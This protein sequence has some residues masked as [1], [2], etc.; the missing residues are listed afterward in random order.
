MQ[1]SEFAS[2]DS[3]Q[4]NFAWLIESHPWFP[5]KFLTPKHQSCNNWYNW[6]SLICFYDTFCLIFFCGC[7]TFVHM[8]NIRRELPK[9]KNTAY[10]A[11]LNNTY[12]EVS[13]FLLMYIHFF[14]VFFHC[15]ILISI[16]SF[17]V[18][19]VLAKILIRFSLSF[20]DAFFYYLVQK[21]FFVKYHSISRL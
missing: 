16:L 9:N 19:S 1:K 12:K 6:W 13:F 14:S 11:M 7:D 21:Q 4:C 18:C 2:R 5:Q 8:Y 3:G 15:A 20:F 10:Q 17:I